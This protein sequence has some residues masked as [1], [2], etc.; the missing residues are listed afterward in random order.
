[1]G[2][3]IAF[4]VIALVTAFSL[5]IVARLPF[6]VEIESTEK[7]ITAG[8]VLG[9]LNGLIR[10]ILAFLTFPITIL[11]LGL[12]TLILN[13]LMFALAASL[14]SGFRLRFGFWS[15]LLGTVVVSVLNNVFL[16]F[17]D[18]IFPNLVG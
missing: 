11:T 8:L 14:I 3:I 13:A 1:M 5:L 6:G 16:G 9:L 7:A 17:L 10:P 12:F 18:S 15:A 2:G 4:L